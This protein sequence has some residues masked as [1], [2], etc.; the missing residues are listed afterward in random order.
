M[1]YALSL[2]ILAFFTGIRI[3]I[4]NAVSRKEILRIMM[5]EIIPEAYDIQGKKTPRFK[6][7]KR[8]RRHIF[9]PA[10]PMGRHVK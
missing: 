2:H 7:R 4:H 5:A 9:Q 10:V 6:V 8:K 3:H 1:T